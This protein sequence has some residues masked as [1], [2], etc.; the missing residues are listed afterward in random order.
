MIYTNSSAYSALV[1]PFSRS[2][3]PRVP[4]PPHSRQSAFAC[5]TFSLVSAERQPGMGTESMQ[6][7]N[8]LYPKRIS[9]FRDPN[10]RFP[11][12]RDRN[13]FEGECAADVNVLIAS[14]D[15]RP[16]NRYGG[17][18]AKRSQNPI[19]IIRFHISSSL[20]VY[21]LLLE[22]TMNFVI[23]L[24]ASCVGHS[25]DE[26]VFV[27]AFALRLVV[28]VRSDD[29]EPRRGSGSETESGGFR[30]FIVRR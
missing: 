18:A 29:C 7:V 22:I 4:F 28:R 1:G 10:S 20:S 19:P 16:A 27:F 30:K 25:S 21:R 26:I 24:F 8:Q 3:I 14:I 17:I 6:S 15:Y 13:S 2:L 11:L 5:E 12:A 9:L 23:V